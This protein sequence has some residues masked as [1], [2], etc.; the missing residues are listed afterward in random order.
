M[1]CPLQIKKVY[2][3]RLM[4]D[5]FEC[6]KEDCGWWSTVHD[7]CG[8]IALNNRLAAIGNVFG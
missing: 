1:K 2:E 5:F 3:D 4:I 7:A 6:V 8:V